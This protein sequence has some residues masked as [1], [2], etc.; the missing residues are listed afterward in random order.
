VDLRS[1]AC[2]DCGSESRR[3][4]RCLSLVSDVWCRRSL[5]QADHPS[6]GV[7]PKVLYLCVIGNFDNKPA[8]VHNILQIPTIKCSENRTSGSHLFHVSKDEGATSSFSQLL[9]MCPILIHNTIYLEQTF[10]TCGPVNWDE[11]KSTSFSLT[12][13]SNSTFPGMTSVGNKVIYGLLIS[14]NV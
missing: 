6:R 8:L 3:R 7:L 12:F 11:G 13:N 14:K 2:W 10:V 1:P 4:H 5:R 9:R